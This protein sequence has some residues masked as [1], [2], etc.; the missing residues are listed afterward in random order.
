VEIDHAYQGDRKQFVRVQILIHEGHQ[1]WLGQILLRGNK[2][3]SYSRLTEPLTTGER[4]DFWRPI[5]GVTGLGRYDR[6]RL[7]D[8]LKEVEQQYRDEGWLAAHVRLRGEVRKGDVVY[9]K[10]EVDEGPH[11]EVAFEGNHHLDDKDLF[12]VTTFAESGAIDGTEIDASADAIRG[13]YQAAAH[14]YAQVRPERETLPDGTVRITFHVDEGPRVYVRHVDLRGNHH[15]DDEDVLK[16]MGT[17]AVAENG[18]ISAFKV[19]PGIL[20]DARVINDLA[21]IRNLYLDRGFLGLQFRCKPPDEPIEAWNARRLDELHGHP[22]AQPAF[23]VWSSDPARFRCFVVERDPQQD[24]VTLHIELDEGLRTTVDRIGIEKYLDASPEMQDEGQDLL[25]KLGLKD[26]YG[27]W[28]RHAGL[29]RSKIEAIRGFLLKYFRQDGH[30]Q[31]RVQPRCS[32]DQAPDTFLS[33]DDAEAACDRDALYGQHFHR[34]DVNADPGPQTIVDGILITGNLRTSRDVITKELL[35]HEKGPLSTDGLFLSQANLRSL[36]IFESVRIETL[37]EQL[38]M[39]VDSPTLGVPQLDPHVRHATAL[40][41]VEEGE[42]RL[43]DAHLGLSVDSSPLGTSSDLPILYVAGLTVRDRNLFGRALEAGL[44]GEH[45]NRIDTPGD[46]QGDDATWTVGPFLH[47]R[48]FFGTR[49]DLNANAQYS[50]GRTAAR[51]QYAERFQ[52]TGD[53]GYDFFNL[54]YPSDWGHGVRANLNTQFVRERTRDLTRNVERPPFGDPNISVTLGPG[55]NVDKRDS[56]LHPTRGWLLREANEV[57]F[58]IAALTLNDLSPTFRETLTTEYVHSFFDRRL[59]VVPSFR[60][61]AVQTDKTEAQLT[62]DILFKAGGD[63]VALPVRGY[64]DAAIEACGGKLDRGYCAGARSKLDDSAQPVG[65]KA[66]ATASMEVR[67]PTFVIDDFWWTLFADAGAVAKQWS[68]M[69]TDRIYPSVGFGLRW[70]VTGQIPLRL[71]VGF[72]L[73]K[74]EFQTDHSPRF[75]LNIF[76]PL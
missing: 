22:P 21:A 50:L 74:N 12:K 49:L 17:Q 72:P 67:F 36:G 43:L 33:E 62:S 39:D 70:L 55:V 35:F 13:A 5:F 16:V 11:V 32:A 44:A 61:G 31:A 56:P 66:M 71:D 3:F 65:G 69:D 45:S 41:S 19:S 14:Y 38:P 73:R 10:V 20:Q 34:L 2:A 28:I 76:Y 37:G 18:V 40:V 47:D 1:P 75:H 51:D 23:D 54:S 59:I 7:L 53:V 42:F 46:I 64:A 60:V 25:F 48:R 6:R 63:I 58:P 68:D 9:P 4:T 57:S 27:N 24:L 15:L 30:L 52:V 8:E 26:E 29:N